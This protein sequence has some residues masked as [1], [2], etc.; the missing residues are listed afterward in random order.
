MNSSFYN[1]IAEDGNELKESE[2]QAQGQEHQILDFFKENYPKSFT[3]FDV[4]SLLNNKWPITSV[5]RSITNLTIDS[6]LEKLQDQR[7]GGY[8]KPNYMWRFNQQ[9]Q[10]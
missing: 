1:T 3:P 8:G 5:R 10:G 4:L 7:P 2:A 6:K 9:L